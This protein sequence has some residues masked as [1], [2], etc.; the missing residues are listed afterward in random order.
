MN[1]QGTDQALTR[2]AAV[3]YLLYDTEWP[4]PLNH[5]HPVCG[6]KW[7]HTTCLSSLDGIAA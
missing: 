6:S 3:H 7:A 4:D 2:R 1:R 5:M